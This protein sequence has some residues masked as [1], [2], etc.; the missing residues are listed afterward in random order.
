MRQI[1]TPVA[2]DDVQLFG[3]WYSCGKPAPVVVSDRI[4]DECIALPFA[5]GMSDPGRIGIRRMRS[6]LHED[7][8][9]VGFQFE[10]QHDEPPCLNKF[11]QYGLSGN[12]PSGQSE[13]RGEIPE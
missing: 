11:T 7:L 12:H 5:D 13:R 8:P 3:M 1:R 6:A 9:V 10:Q 2:F 4:D